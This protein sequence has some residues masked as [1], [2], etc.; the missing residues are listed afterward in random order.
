MQGIYDWI[1]NLVYFYILMTAVLHLLPKSN[2]QKYVRFFGGLL[3]VVLLVS[4]VLEF[5]RHP[6]VLL[7]RISYESFW[8][9][10]DT[11]RLD[12]AGLEELQ[13]TAYREEYEKAIAKDISLMAQEENL[14]TLSA[15]VK[16]SRDCRVTSVALSVIPDGGEEGVLIEK[17]TFQDNSSPYPGVRELKQKIVEFYE[18]AD[19]QVQIMV[20]EG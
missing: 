14:Q 9:E 10:M 16:L 5:F 4:P 15:E 19:S 12:L 17:I 20:Q 6:D 18:V 13:Q 11:V 2:Y 8:Q 3:L 1:K 7:E